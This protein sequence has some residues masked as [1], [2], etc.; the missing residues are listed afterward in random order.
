MTLGHYLDTPWFWA[1]RRWLQ[2]RAPRP[3][4]ASTGRSVAEADLAPL[5]EL[6]VR[7]L[8]D[9]GAPPRLLARAQ[10]RRDAQVD[11]RAALLLGV[12]SAG[13]RHW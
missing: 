8:C 7:T 1:T 12:A 9:I 3:A 2:A 11:E 10:A 13:W 4:S 6:D 5:T